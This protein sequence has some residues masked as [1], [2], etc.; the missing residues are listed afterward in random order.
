MKGPKEMLLVY[1]FPH[2]LVSE[3]ED[4]MKGSE[5]LVIEESLKSYLE[6]MELK[7]RTDESYLSEAAETSTLIFHYN[8]RNYRFRSS[9][10][11][12]CL[13]NWIGQHVLLCRV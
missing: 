4:V 12:A 10:N 2:F 1:Y 11:S 7:L 13:H 9:C 5:F 8:E 3:K 6:R